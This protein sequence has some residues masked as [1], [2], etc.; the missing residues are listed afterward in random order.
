MAMG[1]GVPGSASEQWSVGAGAR[2]ILPVRVKN[3][4]TNKQEQCCCELELLLCMHSACDGD[5]TW[6]KSV[7]IHLTDQYWFTTTKVNGDW[8][9]TILKTNCYGLLHVCSVL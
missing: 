1:E 7:V 9:F 5:I 3:R 6:N 2:K 8:L 4:K